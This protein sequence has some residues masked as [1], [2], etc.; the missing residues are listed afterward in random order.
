MIQPL[1]WQA[2]L[3][4]P[5]GAERH[6]A[7]AIRLRPDAVILD[8]EDAVA[9]EAKAAARVALRGMQAQLAEAGI[10]C[11]VRV[12]GALRAMVDDLNAADLSTLHAVMVPKCEDGRGLRNA[13]E[14][15]AGQTALIALIESPAGLRRLDEITVVPQVLAL[16]LGSEDYSATLG[17]NPDK[18]ALDMVTA[19]LA[20][21]ASPRGL[22]PIGFPGS[23]ANFRDLHLYA[24]QIAKGRD[25]GMRAVAAIHPV[26]LPVIRATLRPSDAEV[27]WAEKVL[28]G[29]GEGGAVFA[30][31]GGMVDAP[32]VARARQIDAASRR[33]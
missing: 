30:L 5:V 24:A 7:S 17:V 15:T 4:V 27:A 14:L 8:L 10:D 16:M 6:L 2:L 26:Q 32:V 11:A 23:I 9:P 25:L 21:A 1:D 19:E 31:E 33:T 20:I 18:G 22:L 28:A 13:A 29:M 12:N 3:F